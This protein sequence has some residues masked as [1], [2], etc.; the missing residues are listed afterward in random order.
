MPANRASNP[1]LSLA[2]PST[3]LPYDNDQD[4]EDN[5]GDDM[6]LS[7][8]TSLPQLPTLLPTLPPPA[9]MDSQ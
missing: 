9:M 5:D 1:H 3:A 2:S 4:N 8:A 6:H 7:T